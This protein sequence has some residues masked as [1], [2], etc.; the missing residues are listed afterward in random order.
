MNKT[1]DSAISTLKISYKSSLTLFCHII[2]YLYSTHLTSDLFR[3]CQLYD[4]QQHQLYDYH[5]YK[6]IEHTLWNTIECIIRKHQPTSSSSSSSPTSSPLYCISF[7]HH[8]DHHSLCT[9]S[10]TSNTRHYY[11]PST[12][13]CRRLVITLGYLVHHYHIYER[14]IG[15]IYRVMIDLPLL[16]HTDGRLCINKP[17]RSSSSSSSSS[18]NPLNTTHHSLFRYND[19]LEFF[20][21]HVGWDH[22]SDELRDDNDADIRLRKLHYMITS[23]LNHSSHTTSPLLPLPHY[24]HQIILLYHQLFMKL[25]NLL[26]LQQ[27]SMVKQ[28]NLI[29][30]VYYVHINKIIIMH[31]YIL[32]CI[33]Y[34]Y[35]FIH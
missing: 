17:Y 26:L 27:E 4:T 13:T 3:Q 35:C 20:T 22:S 21:P 14:Y 23:H 2:N 1:N 18:S 6:V 15:E 30:S 9:V 32:T 12:I 8:I 25:D 11:H 24:A 28:A 5:K 16:P 34:V 31:V 10:N 29:V 19:V 7:L 33:L